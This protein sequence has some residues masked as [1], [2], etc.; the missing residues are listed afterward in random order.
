MKTIENM[1]SYLTRYIGVV[2]ILFSILAALIASFILIPTI[3]K[4]K[5]FASTQGNLNITYNYL[6]NT[7]KECPGKN[8]QENKVLF[9]HRLKEFILNLGLTDKTMYESC[10][11]SF[12]Y[13][14]KSLDFIDFFECCLKIMKLDFEQ[15]YIKYK[16][17]LIYNN[18]I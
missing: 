8:L 14:K 13:N 6:Y 2:I 3:I 1:I 4:I 9:L 17:I 18:A 15:N 16:C 10:I 12:I 7:F 11:R 5:S